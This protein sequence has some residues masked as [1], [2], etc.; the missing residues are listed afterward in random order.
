MIKPVSPIVILAFRLL[1][2]G[3]PD[4]SSITIIQTPRSDIQQEKDFR[5]IPLPP[6]CI[7]ILLVSSEATRPEPKMAPPKAATVAS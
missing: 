3:K 2:K 7:I 6:E 4:I 1:L 5:T